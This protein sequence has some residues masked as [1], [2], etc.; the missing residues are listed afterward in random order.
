MP[1]HAKDVCPVC[2][3]Y[4]KAASTIQTTLDMFF[5]GLFGF[6]S[7]R[8]FF[9]LALFIYLNLKKILASPLRMWD[10]S[11]ATKDQTRTPFRGSAES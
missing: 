1:K 5:W 9:I 2:K 7:S 6:A 8:I 10:L 3:P 4:D 11:S